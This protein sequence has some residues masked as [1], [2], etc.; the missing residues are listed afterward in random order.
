MDKTESFVVKYDKEPC[1]KPTK[2]NPFMN[3]TIGDLIETPH[4]LPACDY[5]KVKNQVREKFKSHIFYDNSNLWGQ[6]TSDR[7]FYIMPNTNI[8]NNQIEFAKWCFGNS[9][10]CKSFGIDCLYKLNQ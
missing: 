5:M 8:V 10:N 6:Q 1:Y 7:N 3:Y 4:R 9:G 2:D